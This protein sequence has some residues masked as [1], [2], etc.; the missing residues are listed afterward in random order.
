MCDM[1][2]MYDILDE[3][4]IDEHMQLEEAGLSWHIHI[5]CPFARQEFSNLIRL[6][7]KMNLGQWW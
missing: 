7:R 3:D 2:R 6:V 5:R 1:S 4:A